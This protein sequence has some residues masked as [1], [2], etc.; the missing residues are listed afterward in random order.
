MREK[1][2]RTVIRETGKKIQ[3]TQNYGRQEVMEKQKERASE[4][5]TIGTPNCVSSSV[6]TQILSNAFVSLMSQSC[7]RFNE[8]TM[9]AVIVIFLLPSLSL[10]FCSASIST[11]LRN[12]S[13]YVVFVLAC[14][15]V[16]RASTKIKQNFCCFLCKWCLSKYYSF[17]ICLRIYVSRARSQQKKTRTN[18]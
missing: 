8:P 14:A 9:K 5:E 10:S 11:A 17:V 2:S 4:I 7:L 12:E 16:Q 15:R 6:K 3:E 1:S 13:M 18:K